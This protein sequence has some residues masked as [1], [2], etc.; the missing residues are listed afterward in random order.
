MQP[1][2]LVL[3]LHEKPEVSIIK[4]TLMSFDVFLNRRSG[5]FIK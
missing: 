5:I 4:H 1:Y 3:Q 2:T